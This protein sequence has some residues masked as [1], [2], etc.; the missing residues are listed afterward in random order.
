MSISTHRHRECGIFGDLGGLGIY[1]SSRDL[2]SVCK[3][4]TLIYSIPKEGASRV[5]PQIV[6]GLGWLKR[7]H[8]QESSKSVLAE[9]AC[10]WA[11]GSVWRN[12]A[13][14]CPPVLCRLCVQVLPVE[15][16]ES[17][18]PVVW[19]LPAA[20]FWEHLNTGMPCLTPGTALQ[21]LYLQ[22][23]LSLSSNI[24]VFVPL[25]LILKQHLR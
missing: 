20:K 1:L 22:P 3:V 19:F 23:D 7:F 25:C 14:L 15:K 17:R 4:L 12:T 13:L 9:R 2:P 21:D 24:M 5:H 16:M 18:N 11:A 10:G 8:I 6:L